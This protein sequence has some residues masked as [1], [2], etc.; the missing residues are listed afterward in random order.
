MISSC[1][2]QDPLP[3]LHLAQTC[4]IHH[5]QQPTK[6]YTFYD[7][8]KNPVPGPFAYSY[9]LSE[10]VLAWS[11]FTSSYQKHILEIVAGWKIGMKERHFQYD[12]EHGAYLS[13]FTQFVSGGAVAVFVN[14]T[15]VCESHVIHL[16]SCHALDTGTPRPQ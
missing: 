9:I 8:D 11:N 2:F 14:T 16:S 4:W 12:H 6:E 1:T 15:Y 5:L 7:E 3:V 10:V 13:N